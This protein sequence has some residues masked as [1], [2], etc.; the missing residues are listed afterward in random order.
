MPVTVVDSRSVTLGQGMIAVAAAR[1]AAAGAGH[2]DV[3]AAVHSLAARTKVWGARHARQPEE[4]AAGSAAPKRCWRPFCRSSRSSR[5]ATAR[6]RKG[7]AAHP[8]RR[9]RL[10]EKVQSY[11]AIEN[12]AVAHAACP[13]VDGFVEQVR[14]VASGEVIVG[15]IGPVVGS[16]AGRHDGCRAFQ[17]VA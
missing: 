11:G 9:S 8:A 13:D 1:L 15:N 14:H 3:V 12:L 7:Q 10:V 4:A 2:D 16:H 17:T 6:W 5:C